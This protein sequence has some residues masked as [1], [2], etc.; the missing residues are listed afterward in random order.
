MRVLSSLIVTMFLLCGGSWRADFSVAHAAFCPSSGTLAG[1]Q[2]SHYWDST[3]AN[4]Y[5]RQT[6]ECDG[7]VG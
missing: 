5:Y 7:T 1:I 3:Q 6:M 4:P 2:I